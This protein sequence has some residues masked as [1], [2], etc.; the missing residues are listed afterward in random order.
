[1]DVRWPEGFKGPGCQHNKAW[2]PRLRSFRWAGCRKE[3]H[4][5][6]G[7]VLHGSHLPLRYWFWAAY[8]MGTLK[9]GIS[10]LQLQRQLGIGSYRCALYLCGRIGAVP[11][12]CFHA[13]F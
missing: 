10:A 12:I 9:P 11:I 13:T 1:M 3:I 8:W 5:T 4:A 6:A 7:T 2:R